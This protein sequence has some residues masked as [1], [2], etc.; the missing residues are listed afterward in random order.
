M[1]EDRPPGVDLAWVQAMGSDNKPAQMGE[2]IFERGRSDSTFVS[3]EWWVSVKDETPQYEEQNVS[4]CREVVLSD[5]Q[6]QE[7]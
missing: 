6:K 1:G 2:Q 7:K 3:V 4:L 5:E